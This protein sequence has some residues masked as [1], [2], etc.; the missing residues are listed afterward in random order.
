MSVASATTRIRT[1]PDPDNPLTHERRRD[2]VVPLH[3]LTRI[4]LGMPYVEDTAAYYEEFGL[5]PAATDISSIYGAEAPAPTPPTFL[6]PEDLAALMTGAH[7][8]Q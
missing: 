7:R 5:T 6:A 4:L 3:R 8:G 2:T 1:D